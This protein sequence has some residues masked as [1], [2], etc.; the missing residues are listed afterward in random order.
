MSGG[1]DR[2]MRYHYG[3]W[4]R[5]SMPMARDKKEPIVGHSNSSTTSAKARWWDGK[6]KFE[7]LGEGSVR[8]SSLQRDCGFQ[9]DEFREVGEEIEVYRVNSIAQL[10]AIKDKEYN[11]RFGGT[12]RRV[13]RAHVLTNPSPHDDG[14]NSIEE[15]IALNVAMEIVQAIGTSIKSVGKQT[16]EVIKGDSNATLMR[17]KESSGMAVEACS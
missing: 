6:K 7:S 11:D 3:A 15:V 14:D 12:R 2:A 5:A 9:G 10:Q 13:D 16:E 4:L 1:E 17:G 8:E